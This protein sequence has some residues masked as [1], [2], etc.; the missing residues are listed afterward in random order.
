MMNIALVMSCIVFLLLAGEILS[1]MMHFKIVN[2]S[3]RNQ[4]RVWFVITGFF[5]LPFTLLGSP[6]EF[7]GIALVATVTSLISAVLVL[8]CLGIVRAGHVVTPYYE[9]ATAANLFASFGTFLFGFSG[10]GIFP[11]VQSD[12]KEPRKF[13]N[14]VAAGFTLVGLIYIV[15]SLASY[16][17]LGSL[18]GED[19]LTSLTKLSLYHDNVVYR[20][21]VT[22]AQVLICGHVMSAYVLNINPVHQQFEGYI[23]IPLR[24]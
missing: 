11:T 3:Y 2:S 23:G 18:I 16:V 21:F 22:I 6:K 8:A 7:W 12:M 15:V 17:I 5:L 13:Q 9:S 24:K 1:K 20:V 4:L 19:M 10:I 14:I